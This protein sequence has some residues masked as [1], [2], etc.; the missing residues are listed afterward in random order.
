MFTSE[1]AVNSGQLSSR[2]MLAFSLGSLSLTNTVPPSSLPPL[3]ATGVGS[4]GCEMS[5]DCVRSFS[6]GLNPSAWQQTTALSAFSRFVSLFPPRLQNL[7]C[8]CSHLFFS[9]SHVCPLSSPFCLSQLCFSL[10]TVEK[11]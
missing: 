1:R 7:Y 2:F 6:L 11:L 5:S 8:D 3:G 10:Q 4:D 9:L